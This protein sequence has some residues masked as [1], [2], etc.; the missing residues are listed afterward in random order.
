MN[1]KR[2]QKEKT[3]RELEAVQTSRNAYLRRK[4]VMSVEWNALLQEKNG[5]KAE[6]MEAVKEQTNLIVCTNR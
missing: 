5:L 2:E 6:L 3:K 4:A 1:A